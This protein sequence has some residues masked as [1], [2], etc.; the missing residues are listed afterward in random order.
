MPLRPRH[1]TTTTT[2]TL[3]T[4]SKTTSTSSSVRRT[5]RTH[6]NQQQQKDASLSPDPLDI[7]PFVSP[8]KLAKKEILG[9]I[10]SPASTDDAPDIANPTPSYRTTRRLK[11]EL[12]RADMR[13]ASSQNW[14]VNV[15]IAGADRILPA[16]G[17]A[18]GQK[19][20]FDELESS[21]N[22]GTSSVIT[23]QPLSD[24]RTAWVQVVGSRDTF[25]P[26][27]PSSE[28]KLRVA[29][30]GSTPAVVD[31]SRKRR[32]VRKTSFGKTELEKNDAECASHEIGPASQ[33]RFTAAKVINQEIPGEIASS[34]PGEHIVEPVDYAVAA[35]PSELSSQS[36]GSPICQESCATAL[37][38]YEDP[39]HQWPPL[40]RSS[41]VIDHRVFVERSSS[42]LNATRNSKKMDNASCLR[43]NSSSPLKPVSLPPPPHSP[44]LLSQSAEHTLPLYRSLTNQSYPAP[45]ISSS[46]LTTTDLTPV[47]DYRRLPN[48]PNPNPDATWSRAHWIL[49]TQLHP[50]RMDPLPSRALVRPPL[51]IVAAF[52]GI[53]DEELSRRMLALDRIRLRRELFKERV[54]DGGGSER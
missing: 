2:T 9:S 36:S 14:S 35:Q 15:T 45:S 39:N 6:K 47:P 18:G 37:H 54:E 43:S 51:H 40:A 34:T 49:L 29:N 21:R 32:A 24:S 25:R 4:P 42:S 16:V 20:N 1:A 13:Q 30:A 27:T 19:N 52:P 5:R 3:S 41:P 17:N 28:K 12:V 10:M 31:S 22:E 11:E 48:I 26:S 8:L 44:V 38:I 7:L 53:S 23:C 46:I 33:D 50:R